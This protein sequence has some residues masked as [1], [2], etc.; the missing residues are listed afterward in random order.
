VEDGSI[1]AEL[2]LL[3]SRPHFAFFLNL[4]R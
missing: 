2:D 4:Y 1:H 3:V